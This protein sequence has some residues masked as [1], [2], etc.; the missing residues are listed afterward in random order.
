MNSQKIDLENENRSTVKKTEVTPL[1][2]TA[3]IAICVFLATM[4]GLWNLF[5]VSSGHTDVGF[6]VASMSYL[7]YFIIG[8]LTAVLVIESPKLA[9]LPPLLSFGLVLVFFSLVGGA[10]RAPF[11]INALVT[12]IPFVCGISLAIA[13]KRGFTRTGAITLSASVTGVFSVGILMLSAYISGNELSVSALLDF[14]DVIRA[15]ATEF[16]GTQISEATE[17][18]PQY[19]LS[20]IDP[21]VIVNEIFNIL[22]AMFILLFSVLAFFVNVSMLASMRILGIYDRVEQKDRAFEVSAVTAVVFAVSYIASIILSGADSPA[23]AVCYN[24]SV[25]LMP[26][27]AMVGLFENLPRK[28]GRTIRIGCFPIFFGIPLLL[29][30]PSIGLLVFSILGTISTLKKEWR[31]SKARKDNK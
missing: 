27:L 30:Y 12:L 15:E 26:A 14:V 11:V 2:K 17:M 1:A 13:M 23:F 19:D 8:G 10:V 24:I 22:P 28:E 29:I 16:F 7:L 4:C 5:G 20:E 31:A 18:F 3:L 9:F 6:M 25:V 21:A